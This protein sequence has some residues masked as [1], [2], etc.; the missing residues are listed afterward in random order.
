MY[1]LLILKILCYNSYK[2]QK[3]LCSVGVQYIGD[4]DKN[5]IKNLKKIIVLMEM[6]T[7][8]N[9]EDFS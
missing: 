6:H 5:L 1:S 4:N 2:E 7:T 8:N 9:V 3:S